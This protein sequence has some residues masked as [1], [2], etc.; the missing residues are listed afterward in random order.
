MVV[1]SVSGGGSKRRGAFVSGSRRRSG[2]TAG[3]HGKFGEVIS[4]S[5]MLAWEC[6]QRESQR[7]EGGL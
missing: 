4:L 1:V 6:V 2:A 5:V 3:H 7:R